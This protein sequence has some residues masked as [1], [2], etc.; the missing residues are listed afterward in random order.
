MSRLRLG[1]LCDAPGEGW[2]SMDLVAEM[3]VRQLQGPLA[4]RVDASALWPPLPRIARRLPGAPA[5]FALNA[6]R[7][8]GRYL[9]HPLLARRLRGRGLDAFHVADHSYAHLVHALP[10][11][12]T[13][14]YCHDLDAFRSLFADGERRPAWF[15][16]IARRILHGLQRAAVVFHSTRAV[17]AEIER[18]GLLDPSRL[19]LAPYGVSP[20]LT[21]DPPADAPPLPEPLRERRYLLHVGS[22]APRKRLDVLLDA[23]ARVRRDFPELLLVQRGAPLTPELRAQVERLG[24]ASALVQPPPASRPELAQLYRGAALVVV[25]SDAEGFGLPVLEAL[26]CGAPVLATDL[27]SLREVG[28]DAARYAP[29]GDA[30][31]FASAAASFL[32]RPDSAPSRESRIARVAGFTWLHHARA[33]LGAYERIR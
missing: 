27:P 10:P 5:R 13:G 6:D 29:P 30:A 28:G 19:V 1:V 7:L 20:E 12:R 32:A 26:A 9:L 33:V 22:G 17:A 4:D 8:A 15:K 25:T 18:R 11:E 3:L 31:S 16:A 24:I 2:P 14:V 23:F 21:P